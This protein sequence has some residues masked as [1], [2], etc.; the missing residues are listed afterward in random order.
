M[1]L[2]S[3]GQS[4]QCGDLWFR[5]LAA[6]YGVERGRLKVGGRSGSSWW[7]K[8]A[9]IRDGVGGVEGGW[10]MEGVTQKV[11]GELDTFFWTDPWL[12]GIPLC[13]TFKHLFD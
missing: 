4:K 7:R 10:F 12:G 8:I 3:R 5:V 13:E 2:C 9:R 11:G 6:R 1:R